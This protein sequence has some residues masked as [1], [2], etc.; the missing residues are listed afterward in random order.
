MRE[1]QSLFSATGIPSLFLIFAVLM[2][3]T[4]SLLGYGTSRQDLRASQLALEQTS[5]YYESCSAATDFYTN[6]VEN[7]KAFQTQAA[8]TEDFYTMT[9]QYFESIQEA[10][11]DQ[12]NHTVQYLSPFSQTQSL[13]VTL[14]IEAPLGKENSP[15][16]ILTWNTI[17]TSDW[18]PDTS[19][20]VYKGEN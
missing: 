17:V 12:E 15:A 11:W 20:S 19:Q 13:L 6:T 16:R 10:A 7:L 9:A 1:R 2:L 18:N 14:L 5:A 8:N 3:V 4:L